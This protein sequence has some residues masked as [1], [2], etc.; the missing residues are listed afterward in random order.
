MSMSATNPTFAMT[1]MVT[2]GSRDRHAAFA[3]GVAVMRDWQVRLAAF[4]EDIL[5]EEVPPHSRRRC[6]VRHATAERLD[7]QPFIITEHL[8]RSECLPDLGM[9]TSRRATI[10]FGDVNVS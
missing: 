8:K 6:E 7:R 9:S 2:R 5:A 10:V 3:C 1:R 4:V